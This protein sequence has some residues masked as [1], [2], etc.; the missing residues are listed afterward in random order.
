MIGF[1][2]E[3]DEEAISSAQETLDDAETDK[4]AEALQLEIEKLELEKQILEYIPTVEDQQQL[5]ELWEE[6]TQNMQKTNGSLADWTSAMDTTYKKYAEIDFAEIY[7]E[8][9]TAAEERRSNQVGQL[10]KEAKLLTAAKEAVDAAENKYGKNSVEY[11]EAVDKYNAQLNSYNEARK[12]AKS[13]GAFS[14][15]IE[16]TAGAAEALATAGTL[17]NEDVLIGDMQKM[18]SNSG[19]A[20]TSGQLYMGQTLVDE[21]SL[22]KQ[23]GVQERNEVALRG[24][25]DGK[26]V[27]GAPKKDSNG[28]WGKIVDGVYDGEIEEKKWLSIADYNQLAEANNLPVIKSYKNFEDLPAYTAIGNSDYDDYYLY[29]D[30]FKRLKWLETQ[31]VHE[32]KGGTY[33]K[34]AYGT[35]N[36]Q[37]DYSL[38]NELGTEGIVTPQGTFTALPSHTSIVPADITK[39][40]W[41]LGEVAPELIAQLD[42]LKKANYISNNTG[43][44]N[45][46]TVNIDKV[47]VQPTESYNM[48][49]LIADVK[50]KANITK[51]NN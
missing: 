46:D 38:I 22:D 41:Q 37:D 10:K 33:G 47:I 30:G 40:V 11:N 1:T 19:A 5:K 18:D 32:G 21:G 26:I 35:L 9:Q 44:T 31:T 13:L 42:S 27:W 48:D 4:E 8:F 34:H 25:K 6:W 20:G 2:Y 16:A 36:L 15:L 43:V 12:T 3:A 45:N 49:K 51:H 17:R 39:N 29:V 50:A 24:K 14:S 23:F 7:K 28:N